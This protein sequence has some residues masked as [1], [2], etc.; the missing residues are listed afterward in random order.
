M[1]S[2][3]ATTNFYKQ[4]PGGTSDSDSKRYVNVDN[5]SEEQDYLDEEEYYGEE[6]DCDLDEDVDLE[7]YKGIYF[8]DD[9]G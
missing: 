2:T 8:N 7:N 5:F 6:D 3:L 9:P 1:E 4:D